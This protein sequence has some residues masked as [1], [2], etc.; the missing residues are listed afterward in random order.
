VEVSCGF[1]RDQLIL[2]IVQLHQPGCTGPSSKW[3]DCLQNILT[4]FFPCLCFGEDAMA[5]SPRAITTSS[6]SRTS[7]L[8]PYHRIPEAGWVGI[9]SS[10]SGAMISRSRPP[11]RYWQTAHHGS[12]GRGVTRAMASGAAV[13]WRRNSSNSS[14]GG[15]VG[16]QQPGKPAIGEHPAAGLAVRAVVR[17]VVRIT[18]TEDFRAAPRHASP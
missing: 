1:D 9:S 8:A 6:A 11:W 7:R 13:Q 15:P 18:D 10:G 14:S 2:Y 17:F 12:G 5:K 16:A 3:T 4:K